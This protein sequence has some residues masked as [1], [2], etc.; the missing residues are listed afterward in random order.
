[1]D[2]TLFVY[3]LAKARHEFLRRTCALQQ[4]GLLVLETLPP[5]ER[6]RK[7]DF[8]IERVDATEELPV[9]DLLV[10]LMV[11]SM[12]SARQ[13]CQCECINASGRRFSRAR[14]CAILSAK[15]PPFRF[16]H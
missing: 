14:E 3:T 8:A 2:L 16:L 1:M 15:I 6:L 5:A 4:V 12:P 9:V 7:R 11:D 10:F 13:V